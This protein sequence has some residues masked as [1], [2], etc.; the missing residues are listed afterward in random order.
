M[1]KK[2]RKKHLK[3]EICLLSIKYETLHTLMLFNV[4][5]GTLFQ[6]IF[7][8]SISLECKVKTYKDHI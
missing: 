6:T 7:S 4:S 1:F 8:R 2:R 5:R 3:T